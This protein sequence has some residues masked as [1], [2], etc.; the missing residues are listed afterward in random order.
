[1]QNVLSAAE[2]G[3]LIGVSEQVIEAWVESG[4]IPYRREEGQLRFDR[5]A[6]EKWFE[7][8]AQAL[9]EDW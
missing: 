2:L 8:K 9:E 4:L 5:A 6:M 7:E 3:L 1:M